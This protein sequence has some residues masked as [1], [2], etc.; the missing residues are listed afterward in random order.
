[1]VL[2]IKTHFMLKQNFIFKDKKY[3]VTQTQCIQILYVFFSIVIALFVH[4]HKVL[5]YMCLLSVKKIILEVC[6]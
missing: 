2:E 5:K 1:M 3:V 4:F 6:I